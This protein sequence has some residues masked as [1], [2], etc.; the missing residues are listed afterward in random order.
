M[1]LTKLRHSLALIVLGITSVCSVGQQFQ[2]VKPTTPAWQGI[3]LMYPPDA[4]PG[5][6]A[7]GQRKGCYNQCTTCT[8]NSCIRCCKISCGTGNNCVR[9]CY[10]AFVPRDKWPT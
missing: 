2:A 7:C 5:G 10:P 8:I 1:K 9:G 6:A 3:D 4:V